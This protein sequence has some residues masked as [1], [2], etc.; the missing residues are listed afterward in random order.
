MADNTSTPKAGNTATSGDHDR[1]QMLSLRKDGTPDQHDPEFLGDY[2]ATL[3]ATQEQFR[4]QAV[5]AVDV[6]ERGATA[7]GGF[8][9][10]DAPQDPSVEELQKKHQAAEKSANTAAEKVVKGLSS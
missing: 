4:Q 9:V 6:A 5:S 7:G 10:E 1:V 3:A 8:R 2:E